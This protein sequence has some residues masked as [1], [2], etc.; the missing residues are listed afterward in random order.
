VQ[1]DGD[2]G[3]LPVTVALRELLLHARHVDHPRSPPFVAAA[4]GDWG[5]GEDGRQT[6]GA[7]AVEGDATAPD[8][9]LL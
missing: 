1:R 5:I 6:N 4:D 7:G 2:A 9:K 8:D 3:D